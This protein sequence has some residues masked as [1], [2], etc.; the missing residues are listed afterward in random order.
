MENKKKGKEH[1]LP[2]PTFI[3]ILSDEAYEAESQ[4]I[5]EKYPDYEF[6]TSFDF[7]INYDENA[8]NWSPD[9]DHVPPPPQPTPE[10]EA[11]RLACVSGNLES[12]QNVFKTQWLDVPESER[13]DK[14]RFGAS[15]LCEA[16]QR[17]DAV[18]ASYLIS[19]LVGLNLCHFRLATQYKSYSVL[20]LYL[21]KGWD[22]NAFDSKD[23]P[24]LG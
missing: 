12:V 3:G 1:P 20:Q 14:G 5:K 22:I 8:F 24:P 9:P 21:D 16:I 19:T 4:R 15:G 13:I 23:P 18:I 17:D 2:S 6:D 10:V 7:S 11:M